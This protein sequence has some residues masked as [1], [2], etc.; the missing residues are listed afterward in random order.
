[1]LRQ[2]LLPF[3]AERLHVSLHLPNHPGRDGEGLQLVKLQL[4]GTPGGRKRKEKEKQEEEREEEEGEEQEGGRGER[5]KR[6]EKKGGGRRRRKGRG[7]EEVGD[8]V[9]EGRD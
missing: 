2:R 5:K 4:L 6:K 7:E 1:M 9:Q 3:A 8:C